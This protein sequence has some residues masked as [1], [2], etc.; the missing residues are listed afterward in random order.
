M[1]PTIRKWGYAYVS[2]LCFSHPRILSAHMSW[3]CW[4][5]SMQRIHELQN[6]LNK[7]H[8]A[9][10]SFDDLSMHVSFCVSSF[11]WLLSRPTSGYRRFRWPSFRL[12][13]LPL[14]CIHAS[15]H[16]SIHPC[17]YYP[18]K[19]H[20]SSYSSN[21]YSCPS[22][23][24]SIHSSIRP[25]MHPCIYPSMQS[26]CMY[27]LIHPSMYP[28]IYPSVHVSIHHLSIHIYWSIY[29]SIYPYIHWV[30]LCP[31]THAC[32]HL[33]I[34]PCIYSSIYL[35]IHVYPCIQLASGTESS[36]PKASRYH[37]IP[38]VMG[39][40]W[41]LCIHIRVVTAP[42]ANRITLPYLKLVLSIWLYYIT[43]Y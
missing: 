2:H 26:P 34:H 38:Y 10:A 16:P 39:G 30:S 14:W 7:K 25:W 13:P 31:S 24:V 43:L 6:G 4:T 8:S 29:A 11:R 15:I 22:I 40:G 23:R 35:S 42:A 19:S 5:V 32:I 21:Q 3:L 18:C 9:T 37:C 33:S 17:I 27:S 20:P 28:C 41:E 1:L 36:W 12:S